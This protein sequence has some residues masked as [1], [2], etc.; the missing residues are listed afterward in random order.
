MTFKFK[1]EKRRKKENVIIKA[2]TCEKPTSGQLKELL[3]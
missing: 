2:K 3:V 1:L